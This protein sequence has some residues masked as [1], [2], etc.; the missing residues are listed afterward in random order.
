MNASES[1][2][3]AGAL[4]NARLLD[5][6][7]PTARLRR[8]QEMVL[9]RMGAVT[10]PPVVA[11]QAPPTPDEA[12]PVSTPAPPA[13]AGAPAVLPGEIVLPAKPAGGKPPGG[14]PGL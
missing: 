6:A 8:R 5:P 11:D 2:L 13:D 12:E 7:H 4:V 3:L 1:A 14:P 9:R 10:P